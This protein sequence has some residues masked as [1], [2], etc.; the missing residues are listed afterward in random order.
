M[1][2]YV[3]I[4]VEQREHPTI[5]QRIRDIDK[6]TPKSMKNKINKVHAVYGEYDFLVKIESNNE[7][8]A[9]QTIQK[10]KS[11]H[12]VNYLRTYTVVHK[13]RSFDTPSKKKK[14]KR[15]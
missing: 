5:S 14:I 4:S 10:I 13:T 3:L 1:L 9:S 11:I 2:T 6:D 12:G 8:D 7:K 15:Q